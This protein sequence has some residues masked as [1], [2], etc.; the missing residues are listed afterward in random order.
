MAIT[1]KIFNNQYNQQLSEP[2]YYQPNAWYL[3]VILPNSGNQKTRFEPLH[4]RLTLF[5]RRSV[6][7]QH[8]TD[9]KTE[10]LRLLDENSWTRAELARQL[11]VS[12]AWVTTVLKESNT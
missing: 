10:Y 5:A 2:V 9:R 3:T 4:K 12:R 8:V 11:S 7:K 1:G 6:Q